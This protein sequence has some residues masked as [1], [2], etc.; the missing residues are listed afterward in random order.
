MFQDKNE[1]LRRLEAL[2][3][4]EE[5]DELLLA[6]ESDD[7]PAEDADLPDFLLEPE[8]DAVDRFFIDHTRPFQAYNADKT[9][10]DLEAFSEEVWEGKP[11][12]SS[13][14]VALACV[15][16]TG[17]LLVVLYLLLRYGGWL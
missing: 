11:E 7:E 9:D 17:V 8:E 12:R 5:E 13:P 6:Q 14:L 1:E 15:L 10:T 16:A 3:Q 2:L 4:E